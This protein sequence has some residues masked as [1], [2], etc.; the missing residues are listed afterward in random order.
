M[1]TERDLLAGRY[2]VHE[3]LGLRGSGCVYRAIDVTLQRQVALK[4]GSP[5]L[6]PQDRAVF[7]RE[8]HALSRLHNPSIARVYDFGTAQDGRPYLAREW[9]AG[10]SL[11]SALD[12]Q[13]AFPED[14][15]RN[16]IKAL[17]RSL[18]EVHRAR[19][20]HRD[21]KPANI[22][23]RPSTSETLPQVE[24]V[25]TDFGAAGLLE[26]S[27]ETTKAGEIFGTP[28]YMTPEQIRGE[29]QSVQTD[30]YALG[31]LL[32]KLIYGQLPYDNGGSFVSILNSILVETV[33][34]PESPSVSDNSRYII[35]RCLEKDPALRFSSATELLQ[36]FVQQPEVEDLQLETKPSADTPKNNPRS[37][38]FPPQPGPASTSPARGELPSGAHSKPHSAPNPA[39]H[40]E[41][42]TSD[43][44]LNSGTISGTATD[45]LRATIPIIELGSI[46]VVS[47]ILTIMLTNFQLLA[48]Y[49]WVGPSLLLGSGL[50]IAG[51]KLS[52][53]VRAWLGTKGT[54]A[55]EK[56]RGVLFGARSR[57]DLTSSLA[58]EIGGLL[59]RCRQLD[60]RL[61]GTS[62]AIMVKD[63]EV[64]SEPGDRRAALI[65]IVGLIERLTQRLSPWY[66]R[67]EKLLTTLVSTMGIGSGIVTLLST[68]LKAAGVL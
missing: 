1:P 51:P 21:L 49:W 37:A 18:R 56:A 28:K 58:V 59:A 7:E 60:E 65:E 17:T 52:D 25:I 31:L 61:L 2:H 38:D 30:I 63:F 5:N 47:I 54:E 10:E 14:R 3:Q 46:A 4:V 34:L 57:A 43:I 53:Y 42:L 19:L 20:I 23:L 55:G 39:P 13:G 27:T 40:R 67:H 15:A 44:Y 24:P 16:I 33:I 9:I 26:P 66:V 68:V 12:V 22:I 8:A 11:E 35:Q 48:R 50:I 36:A 6:S 64:L 29:P 32:F 41:R 45:S 62:L